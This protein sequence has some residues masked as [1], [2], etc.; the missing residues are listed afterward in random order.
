M[1]SDTFEQYLEHLAAGIG[2]ADRV[3]ALKQYCT[4]LMLPLARKSVE[5]KRPGFQGGWLV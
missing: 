2:H 3:N 5:L 1:S 4:G